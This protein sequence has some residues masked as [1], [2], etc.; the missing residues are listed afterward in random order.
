[1]VRCYRFDVIDV[2]DGIDGSSE[3]LPLWLMAAATVEPSCV[4][5]CYDTTSVAVDGRGRRCRPVA[6]RFAIAC[7]NA[8]APSDCS[9]AWAIVLRRS[10]SS[11]DS[12]MS[13]NR[14]GCC[15]GCRRV[16]F[17]IE[18]I[19]NSFFWVS[20]SPD[21]T[22]SGD[23]GS[24][25]FFLN[26][27]QMK[28]FQNSTTSPDVTGFGFRTNRILERF[29]KVSDKVREI[30]VSGPVLPHRVNLREAIKMPLTKSSESLVESGERVPVR[31]QTSGDE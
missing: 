8:R 13:V 14:C 1:M 18:I 6:F 24:L 30:E 12:G 22:G 31:W 9:P 17:M 27:P 23:M 25:L 5:C 26:K 15:S 20:R 7:R 2:I 28:N 10:S 29:H 11:R 4:S 3:G 21:V 19:T 16:V